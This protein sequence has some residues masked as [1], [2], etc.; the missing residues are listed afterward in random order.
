MRQPRICRV[1]IRLGLAPPTKLEQAHTNDSLG[2]FIWVS[3]FNPPL[4]EAK[5]FAGYEP[6]TRSLHPELCNRIRPPSSRVLQTL[7]LAM[8]ILVVVPFFSPWFDPLT[9]STCLCGSRLF[10][11]TKSGSS[12]CRRLRKNA[13]RGTQM[14][15]AKGDVWFLCSR[16]PQPFWGGG[17]KRT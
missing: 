15:S 14:A 5:Q 2:I 8:L 11:E 6:P 10:T 13:P 12:A 16:V 17:L 9:H 3:G 1:D 7:I 4:L